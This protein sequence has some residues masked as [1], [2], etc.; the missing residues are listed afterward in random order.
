MPDKNLVIIWQ[1]DYKLELENKSEKN[2]VFI[3]TQYWD[4]LVSLVQNSNWLIFPWE[5]DFWIVPVEVMAAWKPVFAYRWGWLLE[6]IIEWVTWEFFD[7]K[8]WE[9]FVEK[10]QK[11]NKNK[12]SPEECKKQAE[13]FSEKEF[14]K[15][16]KELIK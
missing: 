9:D 15:R 14:E 5:E 8:N 3:W 4:D 12:Y 1:W 16:I 11:F 10:F 7:N 13:K 6:T 2:I